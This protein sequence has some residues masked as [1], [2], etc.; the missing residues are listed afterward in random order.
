MTYLVRPVTD[1]DGQLTTRHNPRLNSSPVIVEDLIEKAK[2]FEK[3]C[4]DYTVSY[5]S[6]RKVHFNSEGKLTFIDDL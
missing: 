6:P 3:K 1:N 5:V 4:N 2:K